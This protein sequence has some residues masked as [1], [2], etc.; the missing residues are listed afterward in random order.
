[1]SDRA[2]SEGLLDLLSQ[3]AVYRAV[4][5]LAAAEAGATRSQVTAAIG[6]DAAQILRSLAV[7]GFVSRDG[8][9][10]LPAGDRVAFTL[11]PQGYELVKQMDRL[12]EWARTRRARR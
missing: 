7:E 10:D 3:R 5:Y 1:M 6:T 11:T 9:W 4:R 8:T 2:P 12:D